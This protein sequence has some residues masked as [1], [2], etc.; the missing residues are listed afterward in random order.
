MSSGDSAFYITGV[1]CIT[2]PPHQ[3][4]DCVTFLC[5][6]T[7]PSN[8]RHRADRGKPLYTD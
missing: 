7:R 5:H 2:A 8:W 3:P 6:E 1:F 4:N